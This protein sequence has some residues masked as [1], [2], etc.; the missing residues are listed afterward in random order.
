MLRRCEEHQVQGLE[1]KE[2]GVS[3]LHESICLH[4]QLGCLLPRIG[5]QPRLKYIQRCQ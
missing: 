1:E 4:A 2:E 5:G 3:E